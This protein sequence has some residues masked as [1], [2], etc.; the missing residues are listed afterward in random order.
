M[1]YYLGAVLDGIFRKGV[2]KHVWG[3]RAIILT[4]VLNNDKAFVLSTSRHEGFPKVCLVLQRIFKFLLWIYF[5]GCSVAVT[6]SFN[7]DRDLHEDFISN[8]F[9]RPVL[10]R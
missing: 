6:P 9:V 10:D 8:G 4:L 7:I 5:Q 3:K 1:D 2:D